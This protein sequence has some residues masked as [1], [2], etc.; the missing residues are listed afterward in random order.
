M[1]AVRLLMLEHGIDHNH[2]AICNAED[3][4]FMSTL[5]RDATM[6]RGEIKMTYI[7]QQICTIPL[8]SLWEWKNLGEICKRA[9]YMPL[10]A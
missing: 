7:A 8:L 1:I 4:P 10:E 2:Q 9:P 3:G 5:S 6:N